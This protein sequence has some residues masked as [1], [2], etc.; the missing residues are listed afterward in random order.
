[1]SQL[2]FMN[3]IKKQML[4]GFY[5]KSKY[6]IKKMSSIESI[7]I[8]IYEFVHDYVKTIEKISNKNILIIELANENFYLP[9]TWNDYSKRADELQNQL[10]KE[11]RNL[12]QDRRHKITQG[13]R[14]ADERFSKSKQ[15][16]FDQQFK[17]RLEQLKSDKNLQRIRMIIDAFEVYNELEINHTFRLLPI[18]SHIEKQVDNSFVRILYQFISY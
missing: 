18:L 5:S 10:Q 4:H 14:I 15:F 13:I 17:H 8:D 16:I 2:S 11:I 1:M 9:A 7:F 3:M 12:A 6:K